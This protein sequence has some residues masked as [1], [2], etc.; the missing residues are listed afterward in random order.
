MNEF[1]F[2][3]LVM[4]KY[5][6]FKGIVTGVSEYISGNVVYLLESMVNG[7]VK[8]MW[9]SATRLVAVAE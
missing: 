4:D 1:T 6:G 3:Q 9:F 2:G 5:T 8:E 7:E